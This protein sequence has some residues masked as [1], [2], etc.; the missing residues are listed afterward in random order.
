MGRQCWNKF[1]ESLGELPSSYIYEPAFC[2]FGAICCYSIPTN[3][4]LKFLSKYP[5]MMNKDTREI[6]QC[7]SVRKPTWGE[8]QSRSG[9]EPLASENS[10][11]DKIKATWLGH[12]CFFVEFPSRPIG[13]LKSSQGHTRGVRILFDP[14]FSN[15]CSPSQYMGP[16]RYTRTFSSFLHKCLVFSSIIA[17]PCTIEEIPEIDA[18]VISV[19][20]IPLTSH[21]LFQLAH[22]SLSSTITTISM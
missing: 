21:P 12:A 10:T 3:G 22:I 11:H 20:K 19:S 1:S 2:E 5:S 4:L 8:A 9:D 6:T 16:K 15:R 17:P 14:V 13:D 18:V 7:L